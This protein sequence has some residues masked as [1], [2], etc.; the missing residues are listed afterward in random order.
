MGVVAA[1][2]K[3]L[4]QGFAIPWVGWRVQADLGVNLFNN[5]EGSGAEL[6]ALP[7]YVALIAYMF[8]DA[9]RGKVEG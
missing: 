6:L 3:F 2:L 5:A 9:R 4:S 7:F 8:I 1:F